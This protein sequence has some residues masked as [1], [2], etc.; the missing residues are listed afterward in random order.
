M[1]GN[2]RYLRQHCNLLAQYPTD[3]PT[4]TDPYQTRITERDQNAT[5]SLTNASSSRLAISSHQLR[6]VVVRPTMCQSNFAYLLRGNVGA[7]AI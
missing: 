6:A 7:R 1:T 3:V 2:P 5:L 4:S